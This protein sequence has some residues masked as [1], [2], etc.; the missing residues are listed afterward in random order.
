MQSIE[1]MRLFSPPRLTSLPPY[2]HQATVVFHKTGTIGAD[3]W[4][5][6]VFKPFLDGGLHSGEVG[7]PETGAAFKTVFNVVVMRG[8]E[9]ENETVA[10]IMVSPSESGDAIAKFF[11]DKNPFWQAGR[12]D[13]WL[14]GPI[15]SYKTAPFL[16]RGPDPKTGFPPDFKKGQGAQLAVFGSKIDIKSEWVPAFTGPDTDVLHDGAGIFCSVAGTLDIKASDYDS[17]FKSVAVVH[18]FKNFK[19]ADAWNTKFVAAKEPPFDQIANILDNLQ[20]QSFEVISDTT[21][22][23]YLPKA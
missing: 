18:G 11:D 15:T 8:R 21:F 7:G 5:K 10:V 13:G 4:Y 2:L 20:A 23:E 3:E 14:V 17:K 1:R 9:A 6:T 12:D 19:Q 16:V 22:P